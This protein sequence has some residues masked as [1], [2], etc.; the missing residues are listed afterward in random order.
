VTV[1]APNPIQEDCELFDGGEHCW[2]ALQCLRDEGALVNDEIWFIAA[3]V[4]LLWYT[5]RLARPWKLILIVPGE[6]QLFA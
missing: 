3:S 5:I 6:A 1:S 4:T 2:L